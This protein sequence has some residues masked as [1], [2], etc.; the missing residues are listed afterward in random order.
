[1]RDI[2]IL[3]NY[4]LELITMFE[5]KEMDKKILRKLRKQLVKNLHEDTGDILSVVLDT[6]KKELKNFSE[7]LLDIQKGINYIDHRMNLVKSVSEYIL[8]RKELIENL[9][10]NVHYYKNKIENI[11][12]EKVLRVICSHDY[13]VDKDKFT[14]IWFT[15][16]LNHDLYNTS[17][18]YVLD[19]PLQGNR[20][21]S[22]ELIYT[23]DFWVGWIAKVTI[24]NNRVID[25]IEWIDSDYS[26][27]DKRTPTKLLD[28]IIKASNLIGTVGIN[29]FKFTNSKAI[30]LLCGFNEIIDGLY[31]SN[32]KEL[33]DSVLKLENTF[34]NKEDV[35][36]ILD[37][38]INEENEVLN[39]CN[40]NYSLEKM[41]L[42]N[43]ETMINNFLNYKFNLSTL[44]E[45]KSKLIEYESKLKKEKISR[46]K[47]IPINITEKQIERKTVKAHIRKVKMSN[48]KKIEILSF[49]ED[50]NLEIKDLGTITLEN[51][52]DFDW[53]KMTIVDEFN[54][55]IN[56]IK[57]QDIDLNSYYI[58]QHQEKQKKLK[59]ANEIHKMLVKKMAY[60]LTHNGYEPLY[61]I[62]IDL[63]FRTN[64]KII[65]FEMKSI[66]SHNEY[67]QLMKAYSQLK[68][69]PYICNMYEKYDIERCIVLSS[70]PKEERLNLLLKNE[71]INIIWK[72]NDIFNTYEWSSELIC[73]LLQNQVVISYV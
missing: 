37:D 72:E 35:E 10:V 6:T 59:M 24:K 38:Y 36:R 7:K 14:R 55:N 56:V 67:S 73:S 15:E 4:L 51:F 32:S 69:Y 27:D 8:K 16:N 21:Y 34:R 53:S 44:L 61:N 43:V 58:E 62:F 3:Q 45:I 13:S 5:N 65:V 25:I 41:K 2:N 63:L 30:F 47:G 68:V 33:R 20:K 60:I 9:E 70:K 71:K 40:F 29:E 54:K 39:N 42:K 57:K 48:D 64:N 31:F 26:N 11:E 1:M 12:H 22:A 28:G 50:N 46:I 23:Y 19:Y 49:L 52:D 66:N 18:D 17:V